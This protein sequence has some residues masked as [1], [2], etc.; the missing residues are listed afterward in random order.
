MSIPSAATMTVT[1]GTDN[2]A[3]PAFTAFTTAKAN[4]SNKAV[5]LNATAGNPSGDA[6][7]F[8]DEFVVIP[9]NAAS[10]PFTFSYTLTSTYTPTTGTAS[11]VT[12]TVPVSITMDGFSA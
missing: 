1:Y 7:A 10:I 11:V 12:E 4:L 2:K 3:V 9:Q 5:T 8:T 6:V